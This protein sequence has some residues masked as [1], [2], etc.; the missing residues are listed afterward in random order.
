MLK[1]KNQ[2]LG[3]TL[4]VLVTGLGVGYCF[5]HQ[6]PKATITLRLPKHVKV[7]ESVTV[8][9]FID[10]A[11][12]TINAAEIYLTFDPSKIK[13]E[14]VTK[15][16][17]IFQLWITG[18]PS[19]SNSEGKIAFVGGLPTPGFKGQGTI[20]TIKLTPL[21]AGTN[22]IHFSSATRALL[23]DGLGTI[24]PLRLSP[25]SLSAT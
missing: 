14:E 13:I 1:Y 17:S 11:T 12:S 6:A 20:G 3:L 25:I 8:P 2:L 16:E 15:N 22:L 5:H 9:V 18:Q 10:T 4:L 7:N 19:F 21:T 24:M 23:N